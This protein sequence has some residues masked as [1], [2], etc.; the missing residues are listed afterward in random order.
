MTQAV[1]EKRGTDPSNSKEQ[2]K[3]TRDHEPKQPEP[4]KCSECAKVCSA[5]D[6]LHFPS[7][8]WCSMTIPSVQFDLKQVGVTQ[9]LFCGETC[10]D[11]WHDT[12][13]CHKCGPTA[14]EHVDDGQSKR[15]AMDNINKLCELMRNVK[16]CMKMNWKHS[17]NTMKEKPAEQSEEEKEVRECLRN[18]PRIRDELDW[19]PICKKCGDIMSPRGSPSC[20]HSLPHHLDV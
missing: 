10:E 16:F 8:M 13:M 11:K 17:D 2:V 12:L 9:F 4:Q 14:T 18:G 1:A 5:K 3:Q 19:T 20:Q 6:F 15:E 7:R